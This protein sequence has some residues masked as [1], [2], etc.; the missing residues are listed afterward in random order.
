MTAEIILF[1]PTGTTR[2]IARSFAAG[3]GFEICYT[4]ITQPSG[5]SAVTHRDSDFVVIASPVYEERVPELMLDYIK[6]IDGKERPL[7]ILSIYGNV[8]YGQS[9][10]QLKQYAAEHN[11]RLI[12]A[13]LFIGEH[14]F[15]G[16]QLPVAYGRPDQTDLAEAESFGKL[17]RNK[18]D[19]ENLQMIDVPSSKPPFLMRMVPSAGAQLFVKQPSPDTALCTNCGLCAKLCPVGAIDESTITV[20]NTKCIRCLACVKGCPRKAMTSSFR[21]RLFERVFK[22]FGKKHKN[23]EIFVQ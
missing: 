18:L 14:S 11:F 2:K 15:A 13:G 16:P 6:Y 12:A 21:M 20:D 3:L 8:G 22:S 7:A 23:N 17:V 19:T 4:D 9:L 10:A 5:R 1:S